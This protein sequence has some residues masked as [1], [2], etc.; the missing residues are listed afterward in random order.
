MSTMPLTIAEAEKRRLLQV[1]KDIQESVAA[2]YAE[3]ARDGDLGGHVRIWLTQVQNLNDLLT[4]Q[5]GDKATYNTL[6]AAPASA[7]AA[8]I[9]AVKYARN[10]DQHLMHIIAPREDNLIGGA[11]GLRIYA[12]W[13]PIP[14]ATHALLRKRTQDL[15]PAYQTNLEGKEVTGTMLAVLRF[16]AGLAPQI[17]HRDHRGEWTGFPLMNQPAVGAPLHPEE[18]LDDIAAANAWLNGRLPNGDLRVVTGQ[19]TKDGAAYL[20]GFTFADQLS[21]SPFV[22]TIEQVERDI[23]AGFTYLQG[24]VEAN[25]VQ[26]TDRFPR[27]QGGVFHSPKDVTTWATPVTQTRYDKDWVASFDAGW[28]KHTVTLEHPGLLPH[29]VAYEQRRARRLNACVPPR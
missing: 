29:F 25:V 5:L 21:F 9:N 2:Y 28:W 23:A 1:M 3:T 7:G 19:V 6:F 18:P 22:E 8:L 16:F 13:E 14:A 26:V 11:H 24:D 27:A 15:Q 12:F 20:V 17:V 10:V 4:E